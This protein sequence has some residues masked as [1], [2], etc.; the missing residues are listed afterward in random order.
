MPGR[1]CSF[2]DLYASRTAFK[3][4]NCG[5]LALISS[6]WW[7]VF[8]FFFRMARRWYTLIPKPSGSLRAIS[9]QDVRHFICDGLINESLTLG[10]A[11]PRHTGAVFFRKLPGILPLRFSVARHGWCHRRRC[12]H[13]NINNATPANQAG[14]QKGHT[15]DLCSGRSLGSSREGSAHAVAWFLG[16]TPR[17]VDL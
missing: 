9:L 17:W 10:A 6:K 15:P 7:Y 2:L 14:N 5:W 12:D 11:F 3:F 1:T 4:L 8:F 13:F 16:G